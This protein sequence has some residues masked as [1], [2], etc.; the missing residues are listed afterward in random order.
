MATVSAPRPAP[1][2]PT[3][4]TSSATMREYASPSLVD[5]PRSGNLT[6]DVVAN[7]TEHGDAVAFRVRDRAGDQQW[8]D[9]TAAAFHDEVRRVARGLVASGVEVGDRVVLLSK[10]RY[11]WTLLDYAVWFAGGTSVPV[12][13]TS[14]AEQLG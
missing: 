5:L 1:A 8:R 13:E 2:R 3:E 12:Y 10:T 14:S 6:D 4:G 9:V 11:E 7:S